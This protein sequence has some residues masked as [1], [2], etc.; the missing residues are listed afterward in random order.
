MRRLLVTSFLAA[1]ALVPTAAAAPVFFVEGRGWGHGIGMPQYGAQGF[2]TRD[3]RSHAWILA[4]Y[5]RGTTLGRAPVTSVRVLLADGRRALTVGSDAQFSVTDGD[6]RTFALPAGSVGLGPALEIEVGGERKRLVSPARF[7]R[8]GRPLELGGKPYR[9][10]LVVR[11][12]G[13]TLSA[14]NHV[15]LEEYL[16]GVVPDEMPP[17]WHMEALKA[18]AV[19]ARSYAIVSRRTSGVF[20]LYSDTRS[21]VYGGI[22]SEEPRTNAAINATA[23]QVVM[24]AGRVA[25]TFFHSTSGGQTAAIHDVWNAAPVPY[26][27]S[28]PDPHDGISPYHRWGPFRYTAAQ[29]AARL[30]S[31][32][33]S[34][35]LV[36]VTV[37][38]NGSKR[39][40]TVNA[41]G[42][43]S[44]TSFSASSFQSRLELRSTWFTVGVLSLGGPRRIELGRSVQLSG[45]ARG[46]RTVWLERKRLG[47]DWQR[48]AR[49]ARA[50]DGTFR[51]R[52][53]P[54]RTTSF[55]LS[56][57]MG[58]SAEHRVAVAP[59]VRFSEVRENRTLT[60]YVRPA[61]AGSQVAAQRH[62]G[63][64]WA[65]VAT[66]QTDAFGR[67]SVSLALTPGRY[68]G[69]ASVG[70][71]YV[72][73]LTPAFEVVPG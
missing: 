2:A 49:I 4:H 43:R 61:V 19:A 47:G 17:S 68:R 20:D 40:D 69:V 14:V 73:G 15:G 36:D 63:V 70:P 11:S 16:Y 67:F 64:G 37:T 60:G 45:I 65:T 56:A 10:Q 46:M 13:G 31:L 38:R 24:H 5:Y 3:G 55:R 8:G 35:R 57:A 34:G 28:V 50:R 27:V 25:H 48:V 23:G 62:D 6:G 9:G 33:P 54:A 53:K 7:E 44:R 71:G 58:R 41:R 72:P 51:V 12:S 1:L 18:Q 39:A 32:A 52:V 21:Q 29:L 42:S 26:L 22:A 30:G 66:A 59:L